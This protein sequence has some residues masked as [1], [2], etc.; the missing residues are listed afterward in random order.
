MFQTT[1]S[2]DYRRCGWMKVRLAG[3]FPYQD[4]RRN[5][6]A[7]PI[8]DTELKLIA[9][10]AII[11]LS[12]HPKDRVKNTRGNRNAQARCKQRQMQDSV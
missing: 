4:A 10:L 1:T 8:T 12:S 11:G 9:A 7:L 6:S 3:D 2:I 5:R